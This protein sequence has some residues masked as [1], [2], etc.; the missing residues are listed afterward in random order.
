MKVEIGQNVFA[1]YGAM[2]PVVYGIVDRIE[3]GVVYFYDKYCPEEVWTCLEEN[4]EEICKNR[5][6]NKIGV[7][8]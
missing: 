2:Y 7:Y 5:T 1:N 8:A 6:H 4:I 3:D